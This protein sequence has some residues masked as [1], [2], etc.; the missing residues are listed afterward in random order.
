VVALL[1]AGTEAR[2]A[3]AVLALWICGNILVHLLWGDEMFM[4]SPHWSWALAAI[5]LLAAKWVPL[6]ALA[7]ISMTIAVGQ[8]ATLF[9]VLELSKQIAAVCP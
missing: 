5:P 6:P 1:R 8:A 3:L 4:Y 2:T 9:Q 7:G